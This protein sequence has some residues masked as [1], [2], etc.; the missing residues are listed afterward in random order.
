MR[1]SKP[2]HKLQPVITGCK[3][4]SASKKLSTKHLMLSKSWQPLLYPS[5][6][7][8]HIDSGFV[9]PRAKPLLLHYRISPP[10]VVLKVGGGSMVGKKSLTGK[11]GIKYTFNMYIMYI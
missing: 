11:L 10:I 5:I 8:W 7:A 4:F 1:K 2:I 6:N 3:A 9:P